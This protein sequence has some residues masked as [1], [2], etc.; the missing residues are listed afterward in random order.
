M[1]SQKD[2]G[3]LFALVTMEKPDDVTVCISKLNETLF[4]GQK[5]TVMKVHRSSLFVLFV[6]I[7]SAKLRTFSIL[8]DM[9]H[10]QHKQ[11]S[12]TEIMY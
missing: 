3:G 2:A 7:V 6:I 5:I 9:L 4:C 11:H 12:A 1:K 8:G 10:E